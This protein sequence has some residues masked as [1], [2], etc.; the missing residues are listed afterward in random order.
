MSP[1]FGH[2]SNSEDNHEPLFYD[3]THE[4]SFNEEINNER[5]NVVAEGVRK[6]RVFITEAIFDQIVRLRSTKTK[7]ELIDITG[8][9]ISALN[10]LLKKLDSLEEGETPLYSNFFNKPGRK[11]LDKTQRYLELKLITGNDNTLTLQGC[12]DNMSR[13]KSKS[14]VCRDF[15]KAGITRKRLRRRANVTLSDANL[16]ARRIFCAKITAER[17]QRIL[18]LDESGFNLHTST[19]YGYSMENQNAYI[20]QPA[21]RGRNISMCALISSNGV[22]KVEMKAGAYNRETFM[23]YLVSAQEANVLTSGTVLVLD[24]VRFHHCQ[25]IKMFLDNKGIKTIYLPPYS[26]DLNPIEMVFSMIKQRLDRLRPRAQTTSDLIANIHSVLDSLSDF[27]E[28]YRDFW[29]RVNEIL[30]SLQ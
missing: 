30:N 1:V 20:Y 4:A 26:P 13:P 29:R 2:S 7:N 27:V 12:V 8:V 28:F 17:S 23:N 3:G 11:I 18:F 10:K 22:E 25:E 9:S 6:P 19:N 5:S 14:Q 21:S 15:K 16:E 24:N